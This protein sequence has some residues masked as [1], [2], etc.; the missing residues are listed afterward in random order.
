MNKI[1]VNISIQLLLGPDVIYAKKSE[2]VQVKGKG[3][4]SSCSSSKS[5]IFNWT[6]TCSETG[7]RFP[8]TSADPRTLMI[9][10]YMLEAGKTYVAVLESVAENPML[11]TTSTT[12]ARS[13]ATSTTE[14]AVGKA[15]LTLQVKYGDVIAKIM[16]R[17]YYLY[18][19]L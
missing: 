12:M 17:P 7:E 18:R 11:S 9:R 19:F 6:V 1:I 13:L 14:K 2:T 3:F 5:L 8:S 4:L 15:Y 10:P 16:V